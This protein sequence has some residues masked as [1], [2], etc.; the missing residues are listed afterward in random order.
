MN[1]PAINMKRPT[2][3]EVE[4]YRR[5]MQG[6]CG[7]EMY[8]RWM[9]LSRAAI[10][11]ESVAIRIRIFTWDSSNCR[12][13]VPLIP[14]QLHLLNLYFQGEDHVNFGK[15]KNQSTSD[16]SHRRLGWKIW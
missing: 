6:L 5:I 11:S 2:K 10:V 7:L 9:N 14:H 12:D 15:A 3:G 8:L 16:Q 1:Q 4:L 13:N